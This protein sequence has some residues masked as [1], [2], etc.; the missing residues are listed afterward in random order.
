MSNRPV[1][2]GTNGLNRFR[3]V[4]D[5][6]GFKPG[7]YNMTVA[8]GKNGVSGSV[9]F[10]LAGT[11]LGTDNPIYYSGATAGSSGVPV[12]SIQPVGDHVQ[13]DI[14]QISGTTTLRE[15][16]VL[17]YEVYP[18]Y[19]ENA[20]KRPA[21]SAATPSGIDGDTLV[22]K[23]TGTTN[24]WSCAIDTE[25]YE[26]T[27]YIVNVSTMNENGQKSGIFGSAPFTIR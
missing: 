14:I 25:G 19:F 11:Y 7:V 3:F 26:K 18:D 27:Q 8:T 5:T 10:S 13:G 17:L 16:T 4:F 24:M 21:S 23:G 22:I 2:P 1:I 20:P 12:I 15:G 9:K 6:T